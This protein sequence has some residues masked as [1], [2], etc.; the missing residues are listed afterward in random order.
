MPRVTTVTPNGP[1]I[2]DLREGR[3]L[4]R[5]QFGKMIGRHAQSIRRLEETTEPA[6]RLIVCQVANALKVDV[7][8]LILRDGTPQK[9]AD[10]EDRA[11]A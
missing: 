9:S 1:V 6:S 2:R 4:S 5:Q 7:E 11:A 3:G 8:T 10:D